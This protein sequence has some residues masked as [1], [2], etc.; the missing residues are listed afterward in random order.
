M[1]M[2]MMM[3]MMTAAPR[4]V[5]LY[6]GVPYHTGDTWDDGCDLKCRCEDET[7]NLYR[8]DQR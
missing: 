6:N 7:M 2:M 3:M 4:N 8:C 5:C 1:M